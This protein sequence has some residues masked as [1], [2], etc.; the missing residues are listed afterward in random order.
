M[1][2][3]SLGPGGVVVDLAALEGTIVEDPA[4]STDV[5]WK[6]MVPLM[7]DRVACPVCEKR[8]LTSSL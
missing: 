7:G 3:A 6:I 4:I 2:A 5:N 8:E 1:D